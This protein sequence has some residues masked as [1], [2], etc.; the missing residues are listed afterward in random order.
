MSNET[1]RRSVL[2]IALSTIGVLAILF[3]VIFVGG[4]FF[5]IHSASDSLHQLVASS[6]PP[7][8]KAVGVKVNYALPTEEGHYIAGIRLTGEIVDGTSME[9]LDK[10]DT[11][12]DDSNAVGVLFEVNSPGGAVVPSQEIYDKIKS[13]RETKPVVVYVREMAASGAYYSSASANKIIANRGSLIG[14]IGVIMQGFETSKLIEFLKVNPVTLKTGSLKDAGSPTR[15]MTDADK[16]YL[17]D[18]IEATRTEFANDVKAG[19]N[20]TD[21]TMAFMSTGRVVLAPKALEL[22]LIDGIGNR[23]LALEELTKLTHEKKVPDLFYYENIDSLSDVLAQK[24][25]GEASQ[26]L[27]SV[28]THLLSFN[29]KTELKAE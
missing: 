24:F 8:H 3:V 9:I 12:K 22:K 4:G 2:S 11:A 25:G 14:S 18:L 1:G 13:V 28:M 7:S 6:A 20:T 26:I 27:Q 29:A 19:R 10:L 17:Q 23:D 21:E 15:A 5:L 16:K